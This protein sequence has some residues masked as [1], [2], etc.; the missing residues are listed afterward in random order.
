MGVSAFVDKRDG[1]LHLLRTVVAVAEGRR[2]VV[3]PVEGPIVPVDAALGAP[4]LSNQERTALLWWLQSM[5]KASV[6]RR[7]GVSVH[8]VDMYIRRAR[9][10]YA[11]VGRPCPTKADVLMRAVEDGLIHSE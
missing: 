1:R 8:T 10:K 2:Y 4:N 5:S 3:P 7:M 6:A 9:V 11:T